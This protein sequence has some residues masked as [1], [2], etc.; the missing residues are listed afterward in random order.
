MWQVEYGE[1][2]RVRVQVGPRLRRRHW[3]RGG[4]ADRRAGEPPRA[5]TASRRTASTRPRPSSVLLQPMRPVAPVRRAS[6]KIKRRL[7]SLVPP[8]I[9]TDS[10]Q[11]TTPDKLPEHPPMPPPPPPPAH[12]APNGGFRNPWPSA[13]VPTWTEIIS[14]GN[15]LSWAHSDLHA[16]DKARRIKVVRPDWGL[17]LADPPP[18]TLLAPGAGPRLLATWLGHAAAFVQVPLA[19]RTNQGK[20]VGVEVS[21]ERVS[22]LF[23]PI[24]SAR[25]G[26]TSYT[27]PSRINQVPCAVEDIPACEIVCISHN[28]SVAIQPDDFSW[29]GRADVVHSPCDDQLPNYTEPQLRPPG[30]LHH[31]ITP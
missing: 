8:I 13:Q 11:A 3:G 19:R 21:E 24:F 23:D 10:S 2:Q 29:V 20:E 16:H 4:D 1:E 27:G 6:K 28:Q 17:G 9:R 14:G 31:P 26:P 25:A 7:S 12:H 30:L 15:P 22:I 5:G 18:V